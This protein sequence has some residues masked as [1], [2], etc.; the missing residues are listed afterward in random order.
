MLFYARPPM[1]SFLEYYSHARGLSVANLEWEELDFIG[2]IH[3]LLNAGY[4]VWYV[5]SVAQYR[6]WKKPDPRYTREAILEQLDSKFLLSDV[7]IF[8]LQEYP[9]GKLFGREAVQL[10]QVDIR[11]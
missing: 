11:K 7:E 1:N 6:W 10:Y 4:S 9:V 8:T 3:R 5:D 2:S